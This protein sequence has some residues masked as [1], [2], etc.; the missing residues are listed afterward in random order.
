M[1]YIFICARLQ[2]CS[3]PTA[4]RAL[5][6]SAGWWRGSGDPGPHFFFSVSSRP[7]Q[8]SSAEVS[9]RWAT[10]GG[11]VRLSIRAMSA[12]VS[13]SRTHTLRCR[14]PLSFFSLCV[15]SPTAFALVH[16]CAPCHCAPLCQHGAVIQAR[17]PCG[18]L[19]RCRQG[20]CARQQRTARVAIASTHPH[21]SGCAH[22]RWFAEFARGWQRH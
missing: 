15:T 7:P 4:V 9:A 3:T 1:C 20:R 17:I 16:L 19:C 8:V 12:A 6:R 18:Q 11:I 2:V 21:W 10:D 14:L 5:I 22:R 13:A